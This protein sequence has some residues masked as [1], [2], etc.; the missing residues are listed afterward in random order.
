MTKPYATKGLTDPVG[1]GSSAWNAFDKY[2]EAIRANAPTTHTRSPADMA[3]DYMIRTLRKV[4]R[5]DL[6][7]GWVK[8]AHE[9][10][11]EDPNE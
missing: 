7:N 8:R 10:A 11:L 5:G 4:G 9:M 1:P 6:C 3:K 2:V